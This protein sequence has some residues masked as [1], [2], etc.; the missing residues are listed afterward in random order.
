M[1]R[2]KVLSDEEIRTQ[3]NMELEAKRRLQ[4]TVINTVWLE[5]AT[6]IE[7]TLSKEHSQALYYPG[8][9]NPGNPVKGLRAGMIALSKFDMSYSTLVSNHGKA[10]ANAINSMYLKI[11]PHDENCDSVKIANDTLKQVLSLPTP[12]VKVGNTS[13]PLFGGV[14]AKVQ[15]GEVTIE[16][17]TKEIDSLPLLDKIQVREV[18]EIVLKLIDKGSLFP[19]TWDSVDAYFDTPAEKQGRLEAIES[20]E[21]CRAYMEKSFS[22]F[23]KLDHVF[24]IDRKFLFAL[25]NWINSSVK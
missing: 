23:W 11:N 4:S 16:N 5:K 20:T 13:I 17:A 6:Y 18:A 22:K 2:L 10:V 7:G 9:S 19:R 24:D 8:I 15:N 12:K 14:I 3:K 1:T 25:L 21:L